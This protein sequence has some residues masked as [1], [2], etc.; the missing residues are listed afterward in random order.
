MFTHI[1][2]RVHGKDVASVLN[3]EIGNVLVKWNED[4]FK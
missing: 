3:S 1:H 2:H 4:D